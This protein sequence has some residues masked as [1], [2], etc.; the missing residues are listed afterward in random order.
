MSGG[1]VGFPDK[2]RYCIV[3][4]K[5]D[6]PFFWYQC[7][8][9]PELAF[10]ITN[11][12]LFKGDYHIDVG[13]VAQMMGLDKDDETKTLECYVTVTIPKG[14]PEKMTANLMG[15]IIV[16]PQTGQAVQMVLTNDVYSHKHCLVGE[17]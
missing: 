15:P 11:P 17:S 9:D 1:M 10:V 6:S 16:C 12:W 14:E 13:S 4:H 3:P 8:D 5:K 7:I 2:K